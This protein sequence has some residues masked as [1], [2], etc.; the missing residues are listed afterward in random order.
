MT[1]MQTRR[2]FLTM[3]AL[4][5]TLCNAAA[6]GVRLNV[7]CRDSCNQV[8]PEPAETAAR[9]SAGTPVLDVRDRLVCSRCG[10]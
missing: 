2:R 3:T 8:E 9:Y 7:W 6:N 4:A 10:G 1:M 5:M